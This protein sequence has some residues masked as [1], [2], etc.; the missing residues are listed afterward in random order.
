MDFYQIH[1]DG[2]GAFVNF[3]LDAYALAPDQLPDLLRKTSHPPHPLA[4][5]APRGVAARAFRPTPRTHH[6]D[7]EPAELHRA[8]ERGDERHGQRASASS[9]LTRSKHSSDDVGLQL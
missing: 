8:P 3:L 6:V 9:K 1:M 5:Q 4:D 7:P 2:N